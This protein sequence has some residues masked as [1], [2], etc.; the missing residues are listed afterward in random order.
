MRV[1][2]RK[3]TRGRWS[4]GRGRNLYAP[5][6][7][8]RLFAVG[9][10]FPTCGATTLVEIFGASKAHNSAR[11][12][13]RGVSEVDR[14]SITRRTSR[15]LIRAMHLACRPSPAVTATVAGT[16][17]GT[18]SV[19]GCIGI[20]IFERRAARAAWRRVRPICCTCTTA[21]CAGAVTSFVRSMSIRRGF[22]GGA[23][24]SGIFFSAGSLRSR[25]PSHMR[26]CGEPRSSLLRRRSAPRSPSHGWRYH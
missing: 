24:V 4:V 3:G 2:L 9:L 23:R 21:W 11:T 1:D 20:S 5:Y 17:K 6:A 16:S 15:H 10:P 13:T 25:S 18:R 26:D 8:R 12:R 22:A 7:F 14:I 19:T